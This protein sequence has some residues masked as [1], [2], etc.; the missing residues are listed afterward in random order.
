[1]KTIDFKVLGREI[2]FDPDVVS[3][4]T[5][6]DDLFPRPSSFALDVSGSCN[7]NCV[8]CAEN[9]TMP[10]REPMSEQILMKCVDSIFGWLGSRSGLSIHLG[11]GEP[12]LNSELIQ[13]LC[14]KARAKAKIAKKALSLYLTTNGTLLTDQM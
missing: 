11:S 4:P 6:D 10:K 3:P 7:L 5:I 12:L 9:S 14:E 1:M 8:Y 13:V 2:S